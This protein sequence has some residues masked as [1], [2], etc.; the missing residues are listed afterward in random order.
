MKK[1]NAT[2]LIQV[3]RYFSRIKGYK[4]AP[5]TVKAEIMRKNKNEN[6]YC[7]TKFSCSCYTHSFKS[8]SI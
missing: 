3:I 5:T 7:H 2:P 6:L 1:K 4:H 8:H